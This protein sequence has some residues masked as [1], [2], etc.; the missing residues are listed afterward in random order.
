M[1]P[2]QKAFLA[3]KAE[4]KK[5]DHSGDFDLRNRITNA[6]GEVEKSQDYFIYINGGERL[7]ER[8][9]GSGNLVYAN[10]EAAGR[11]TKDAEG[12]NIFDKSAP[13]KD[14][15]APLSEDAAVAEKLKASQAEVEAVRKELAAIKAEK[16]QA[17]K[18]A[19]K[20]QEKPEA[21]QAGKEKEK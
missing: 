11:V 17:Q 10:N 18:Q 14:Y 12:K 19:E 9:P 4:K 6:E 1:T 15:A 8:P 20:Q 16:E 5:A 21:K 3:A 13:H 7:F 2:E